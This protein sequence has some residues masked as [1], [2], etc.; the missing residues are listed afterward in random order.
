MNVPDAVN[1]QKKKIRQG[2]FVAVVALMTAIGA[3]SID[4]I[5]PAFPEIRSYLGLVPDS[6]K[7]SLLVTSY[8]LGMGLGQIPAGILSD[9]FGRKRGMQVFL[10]IYLV[11]VT[12]TVLAPSL[13]WMIA[14][15]IVAGVGSAGPRAIAMAMVRDTYSGVRMA[16]IL[17]YVQS[18]FAIVPVLAPTIGSA[19]LHLGGW[20][21]TV[22]FPGLVAIALVLWLFR[23]PESLPVERRR[24][25][26]ISGIRRSI[27]T[28]SRHAPT[29]LYAAALACMFGALASYIS[30][31]EQV[32]DGTYG[33]KS[34]F[35][36]IFG[37]IAA[38]MGASTLL[39]ARLVGKIGL[40]VMVRVMPIL[41]AI[42][43]LSLAAISL[44]TS[45]RPP[46]LL[47]AV[48]MAIL[49]SLQTLVVPNVNTTAMSP[50]GEL[51]GVAAGMLGTVGTIGGAVLG[52]II[53]QSHDG[54]T[55][56]LTGGIAACLVMSAL[57]VHLAQR[58]GRQP[59]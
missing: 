9:R 12:L 20:R 41:G 14:A 23:I 40:P 42:F 54:T 18:V 52:T 31:S 1:S 13:P 55:R 11:G 46:F 56:A 37:A 17:S 33:R 35:P 8:L 7:V 51:A 25:A 27:A 21:M 36:L 53:S 2:E 29:R 48:G 22:L 24:P 50:H 32:V 15:R 6:K 10:G 57:F 5:L 26:S 28:V 39:N 19:V 49:L 3:L 38:S 43:G 16:Q 34:H 4:A 58:A 59:S 47:F 30:L 45:G 44:F